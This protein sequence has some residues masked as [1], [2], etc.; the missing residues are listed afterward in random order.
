MHADTIE[1]KQHYVI[2]AGSFCQPRN[3]AILFLG[4]CFMKT[5]VTNSFH[6]LYSHYLDWFQKRAGAG[7]A[8]WDKEDFTRFQ[9]FHEDVY[10]DKKILL[11]RVYYAVPLSPSDNPSGKL[12]MFTFSA[13]NLMEK[14]ESGTM[15]I[16]TV[17]YRVE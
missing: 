10:E 5:T 11:N 12:E 9:S 6:T 1:K 16:L 8:P 3:V 7:T 4:G 17:E 14:D 13:L 15:N 2:L